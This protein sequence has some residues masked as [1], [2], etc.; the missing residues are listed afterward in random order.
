[1]GMGNRIGLL[2][3]I[4]LALGNVPRALAQ[5]KAQQQGWQGPRP[6]PQQSTPLPTLQAPVPSGK[7]VLEI[8]PHPQPSTPD[9]PVQQSVITPSPQPAKVRPSQLVT[10][11]VTDRDGR[12]VPG[13]RPEDFVLYEEDLPQTIT[14]FNTGQ[15]E[16]VSL[17]FIVDTSGSMFNKIVSARRALRRFL[18]TVRPQDEVFLEAFNQRPVLLQDFTDSRALLLQ[19][20]TQLQPDGGTALYDAILDG[21]RR[22][23]Q[24]RRQKKALIVLTDGLDVN[25][26]ASRG[27]T[28]E[29]IRH[30]G[31][32]VYTIGVGNPEGGSRVVGMAPTMSPLGS[33]LMGRGRMGPFPTTQVARV[34]ESVDSLT[35][36]E[37]SDETGGKYFLL[38]TADVVGN[39]MVL[40]KATQAISDELRQQY[41]LGYKSPLKGDVYRSIRIEVRRDGLTVRTHKGTG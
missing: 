16:P 38:N 32:L 33:P 41:S 24:G 27:Q 11:T 8:A 13:L 22:V 30:S 9:L 10:V 14:Y 18:D 17:G 21:L 7:Q 20:T 25:S 40:D 23:Q 28:I 35:L 31:V 15:D 1:M 2:L 5:G 26:D 12:Y 4:L 34:D 36:Q 3:V 6:A 19:A 39:G 37:L 29:A